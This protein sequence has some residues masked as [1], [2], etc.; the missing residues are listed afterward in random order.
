VMLSRRRGSSELLPS[1]MLDLSVSQDPDCL[2]QSGLMT[3]TVSAGWLSQTR[4]LPRRC[5]RRWATRDGREEV[6]EERKFVAEGEV[7]FL[8]DGASSNEN[9]RA[10][11]TGEI[12][13]QARSRENAA[14]GFANCSRQSSR[15]ETPET[16]V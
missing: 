9:G 2:I 15:R 7:C 1:R 11:I 3:T 13:R 14:A 5:R 10:L 16:V 8:G 12:A 6:G 4:F